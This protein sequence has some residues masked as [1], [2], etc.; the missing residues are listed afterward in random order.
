[1]VEVGG[2]EPP[3]LGDRPGL[4]RA[5]PAVRSRL[6]A[7]TGGAPLGQLGFDVRSRPPSG[8]TSVSLLT[9]SIL[10]AQAPRRGRLPNYLGSERVVIGACIDPAFNVTSGITARFSQTANVRI[11]ASTP[12]YV[13]V[14]ISIRLLADGP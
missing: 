10:Q 4:L 1:M 11:E 6:E 2:I 14:P 13:V 7:P 5:Q 9:T 8:T 12:P 3:C